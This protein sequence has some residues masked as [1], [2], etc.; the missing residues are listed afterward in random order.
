MR[1]RV[2]GWFLGSLPKD[3]WRLLVRSWLPKCDVAH[4]REAIFP[5]DVAKIADIAES[6][7]ENHYEN[8]VEKLVIPEMVEAPF[9]ERQKLV[10]AAVRTGDKQYTEHLRYNF[11]V[12][13]AQDMDFK[14]KYVKEV[15]RL[16]DDSVV[17][18]FVACLGWTFE[19]VLPIVKG[20]NYI[21]RVKLINPCVDYEY[22]GLLV[23]C[24]CLELFQWYFKEPWNMIDHVLPNILKFYP[25]ELLNLSLIECKRTLEWIFKTYPGVRV[26]EELILRA[27]SYATPNTWQWLFKKF[28]INL[29]TY[30]VTR[31]RHIEDLDFFN[32]Y[33]PIFPFSREACD[34]FM[35]YRTSHDELLWLMQRHGTP[36]EHF[37]ELK[38]LVDQAD[39]EGAVEKFWSLLTSASSSQ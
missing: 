16:R 19:K 35:K 5:R 27:I 23:R 24:D 10:L 29:D 11:K 6:I 1:K 9:S 30:I 17:S 8:L 31:V 22:L 28:P 38:E 37:E 34:I 20:P 36:V 12:Y 15:A 33:H 4:L 7:V 32:F 26:P 2:M 39:S 25:F 3:I 13:Y 18:Q 14:Y 21:E